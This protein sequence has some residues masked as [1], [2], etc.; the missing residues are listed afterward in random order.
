MMFFNVKNYDVQTIK[1][2]FRK[3][4]KTLLIPFLL[5]NLIA[6]LELYIKNIPCFSSIFPNVI[7]FEWNPLVIIRNF[8]A[9]PNG[10]CPILYPL[11]YVRDLM[12]MVVLSP[13]FY[14]LIKKIRWFWI[15]ILLVLYFINIEMPY[16][17]SISSMLFFSFGISWA[18]F[19]RDRMWSKRV[20]LPFMVAW[21]PIAYMDTMTRSNG[22]HLLSVLVGVPAIL[23]IGQEVFNKKWRVKSILTQSVF[24]VFAAHAIILGYVLKIAFLVFHPTNELSCS[25]TLL[26][27]WALTIILSVLTYIFTKRYLPTLNRVMSGGR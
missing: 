13:L 7:K 18:L 3:R 9:T 16:G 19:A 6:L 4:I 11:W 1:Y 23:L 5:W 20:L 17:F 10:G 21:F 15:G 2:K 25:L 14:M 22:W 24:W 26:S 12:V 27:A 8:W